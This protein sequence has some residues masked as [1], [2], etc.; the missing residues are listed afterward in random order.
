MASRF[1]RGTFIA[2]LTTTALIPLTVPASAATADGHLHWG[3]RAS[4]NSY[5][6]GATYVGDGATRTDNG[7]DFELTDVTFDKESKRTEAQFNGTILYRKY[8]QDASQP[9]TSVCDLDLRFEDPKVVLSP[10]E[11]YLEAHVSSKQYLKNEIYAPK[12]A[13]KIAT[14][15]PS[16][17]TFTNEGG[18]VS[19]ENIA[20]TLTEEGNRMFSE[21]YTVGEGLDPVAL[22]YV[23]EGATFVES[24]ITLRTQTWNSH[25]D[26]DDGVHQLFDTGT[27]VLVG[28][29]DGQGYAL[30]DNNLKEIAALP[31]QTG[32]R[33]LAAYDSNHKVLYYVDE[34]DRAELKAVDITDSGFG[35]PRVAATASHDIYAVGYHPGTDV[36][37]AIVP[38][39]FSARTATLLSGSNGTFTEAPL[40]TGEQLFGDTRL[41]A[42]PGTIWANDFAWK[43]QAELLP[44]K[45]GTFL[46]NGSPEPYFEGEELP[47]KSL[48]YSIKPDAT[49]VTERATFMKGSR[50]TSQ[51]TYLDGLS[52][53][54]VHIYRFNSNPNP[55]AAAAQSLIY[56]PDTRDVKAES[57][58]TFGVLPGWAAVGFDADGT[59][60]QLN[61]STGDLNWL[62]QGSFTVTKSFPLPN[63]RET[64]NVTNNTFLVRKDGT[65]FVPTLDESRGDWKEHYVLR[66]IDVASEDTPAISEEDN[67]A[68]LRKRALAIP[69]KKLDDATSALAADPTNAELQ[70]DVAIAQ[71]ELDI[72]TAK[73]D[74]DADKLAAAQQALAKA[75]AGQPES[76]KP[77]PE[78]PKPENTQPNKP[79]PENPKPENTQPNK[80]KPENPKPE[81]TQPNKPKP[82]NPKPEKP[83]SEKS[84]KPES[85]SA[86]ATVAWIVPILTL[87]AALGSVGYAVIH[88]MIPGLKL[89]KL[90]F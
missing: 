45:D 76:G 60:I 18:R 34:T 32:N 2:A 43:N 40:P 28:M 59:P 73:L 66:R 26:Y 21:F 23:G 79:K 42:E 86:S 46:Y 13:V 22:N 88:G 16:S 65:M 67:L 78:N 61:G 63:G 74:N 30:I 48:L 36:I 5:T 4:F 14:L 39:D 47:T 89:P 41:D 69:Q 57:E 52:T 19:W 54:G 9:M 81:N 50:Y 25:A 6:N 70:R 17:A 72:A 80:P 12:E 55:S 85:M 87:L 56:D 44:M 15:K 83:E 51:S 3:I 90:P 20:S 84:S 11:S 37:A 75:Q 62:Q 7:F 31:A 35:T 77:K 24:D 82:E 68:K 64:T 1:R 33:G 53:D 29:P 71:A 10:A 38:E 8:C 49:E 27:G 58:P